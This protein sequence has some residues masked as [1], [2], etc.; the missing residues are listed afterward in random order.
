M[1]AHKLSMVF[2]S[3]GI[4]IT[5]ILM[6]TATYA[7]F[8]LEIDGTGKD[9][10]IVTFNKNIEITYVDTSN[11][12]MVNAY[13]GESISK[14]FTVENTGDVVVYY[15][16]KLSD[17]VNNF[18]NPDDLV[19]TLS[20][21]NGG[22]VIKQTVMPVSNPVIASSVKIEPGTKHSY[23]MGITLLK[24]DEDQSEN[25]NKTFSAN[26]KVSA[27]T[28]YS[29]NRNLYD[30][31]TLG[32]K[33]VSNAVSEINID[34]STTSKEGLFYT[35]DSI[36][37][38]TIFFYRG[39]KSLDNNVLFAGKCFKILRTTID[40][41]IRLV[42]NGEAS[43]GVCSDTATG[44]IDVSSKYNNSSNYNA[45]VGFM[46]GA[47]N[48]S[49][50]NDEHANTNSS[51]I[52]SALDSW[53]SA[54]IANFASY[55]EDS[56]YCNNRKTSK[57]VVNS[58]TYGIDGF[59]N[60][61]TGYLSFKNNTYN[62]KP[63][64]DCINKKDRLSV[65]NSVGVNVLS[66]PVGLITADELSF[67]GYTTDVENNT[68]FLYTSSLYWTMTP[69]FYNGTKAYNYISNGTKLGA[70]GVDTESGIRPVIT[71]KKNT[72]LISGD[73]SLTTPYKINN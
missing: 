72:K 62:R 71:L 32:E 44:I 52:K 38:E 42:Y 63:S 34:Y 1:R 26:I 43:N 64:Y 56:I 18:A 31:G 16:I 73:G 50:Y 7:Y 45:Y 17:L 48:S 30:T 51:V 15:D 8:S 5:V 2:A 65:S 41:G 10:N 9:M 54:N 27:S 70:L 13:T 58:V 67:A 28:K 46:Y 36:N 33:I 35:N 59:G 68:N 49:L 25:M 24:T 22:A 47:A 57:F 11:V 20:G 61:N 21:S 37:G 19:F 6:I 3:I 29:P 53:Y 40:G 39:S 4:I 14:T 66:N 69:A 55:I 12:S 60:K 23:V